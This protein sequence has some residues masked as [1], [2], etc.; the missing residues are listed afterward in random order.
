VPLQTSRSQLTRPVRLLILQSA[1]KFRL[2]LIEKV[3]ARLP[4]STKGMRR[5][6]HNGRNCSA[7]NTLFAKIQPSQL[8]VN[9]AAP[10][11]EHG[12]VNFAVERQCTA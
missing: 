4:F 11:D 1:R 5:P 7:V 3:L 6:S 10:A 9:V 12:E 8:K 2:H